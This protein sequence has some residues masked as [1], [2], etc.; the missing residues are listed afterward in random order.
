MDAASSNALA[1]V[2][3][4]QKLQSTKSARMLIL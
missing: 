4:T 3:A 1:G 2:F